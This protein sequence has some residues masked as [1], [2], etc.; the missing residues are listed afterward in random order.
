MT[1]I[2]ENKS[3]GLKRAMDLNSMATGAMNKTQPNIKEPGKNVGAAAM[4]G[5]GAAAAGAQL[6]AMLPTPVPGAGAV[7]GGVAGLAQYYLS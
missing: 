6:G 3:T 4:S 5:L 1:P 7:I 2:G